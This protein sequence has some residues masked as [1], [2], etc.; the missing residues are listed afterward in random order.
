MQ[1]LH[2]RGKYGTVKLLDKATNGKIDIK[3]SV[4][5][6]KDVVQP[7]YEESVLIQGL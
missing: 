3:V 5:I 7:Y 1:T 6:M 2:V 4:S